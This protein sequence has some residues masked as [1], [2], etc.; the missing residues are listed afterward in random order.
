MPI[1]NRLIAAFLLCVSLS[2]V[3]LA[4]HVAL[5][6]GNANYQHEG[7]LR[8]PI[9]DARLLS[10]TLKQDLQ[11]DE[12]KLVENADFR[13]LNR[14]VEQFSAMSKGADTAVIYFSGHGQQTEDKQ[15]YLLAVD[16]KI[17]YAADLQSS[18]LS[19]DRLLTA[20][21][22]AR[23]RLVI[24]D[25]CRDRP[26][27]A[28]KT[29]SGTKGLSRARDPS[30]TGLLVAYA[31]EDGKVALDGTG[32]NSPYAEALASALKKRDQPILAMLDTVADQV[33]RSTQYQQVPTRSGNLR[34]DVY[35]VPP[36]L[37]RQDDLESQHQDQKKAQFSLH[38]IDEFFD[39]DRVSLLAGGKSEL[40]RIVML[41]NQHPN[42]QIFIAVYTDERV[43]AGHSYA[44]RI[45]ERRASHMKQYLSEHLS[46]DPRRI[47]TIGTHTDTVLSTL[48]NQANHDFI[49]V[50]R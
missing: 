1:T 2:D 19:S 10:Q 11:F 46:V 7:A 16:A 49:L 40:E 24:L 35:L 39:I 42:S 3:A 32:R 22:G 41:I 43:L 13:T 6:I 18:A 23:T 38:A 21:E 14:A 37:Q 34:T 30:S 31:T 12:V 15:N 26:A 17:E 45:A 27:S 28:Y 8:N 36:L 5:V 29:R 47:Q 25:A 20:T 9:N 33:E 4:R 48:G 50:I 44:L